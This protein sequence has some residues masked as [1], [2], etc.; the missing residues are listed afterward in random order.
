MWNLACGHT[1]LPD[2][3]SSVGLGRAGGGEGLDPDTGTHLREEGKAE[4]LAHCGSSMSCLM[5]GLGPACPV[6][7]CLKVKHEQFLP[8]PL[9]ALFPRWL[10]RGE[11]QRMQRT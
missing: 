5:P 7:T 10:S 3:V 9:Q 11:V 1:L 2:K 6:G 8:T 4:R